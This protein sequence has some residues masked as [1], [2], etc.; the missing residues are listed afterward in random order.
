VTRILC[1]DDIPDNLKLL[2]DDL[3][4]E[5]FEVQLASSGEQALLA[6]EESPPDAILLD[7]MMPGINGLEVLTQIRKERNLTELPI[8]MTTA[9]GDTEHIVEALEAGAN[10]Y[11]VKPLEIEVVLARL[12]THLRLQQLAREQQEVLSMASHDLKNPLSCVR[13][14]AQIL[15]SICQVDSPLTQEAFD[16]F[17]RIHKSTHTMLTIIEDFLELGILEAG[18]VQ[19]K[20]QPVDLEEIATAVMNPLLPSAQ[21]K[22]IDLETH[23]QEKVRVQADPDRLQQVLGNLIGNA[24]KFSPK[25]KSV[26]IV[27]SKNQTNGILEVLD[28]GPGFSAE[29]LERI[30]GKF[31]KL[32]ARPTAGEKSSGLGLFICQKLTK[33][34]GGKLEVTNRSEQGAC[35]QVHHVLA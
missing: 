19:V 31:Q 25:G 24:I 2:Q 28:Q 21:A 27:I 8:L 16:L 4:D 34:Q 14:F 23:S 5:G 10:D 13:G 6:V 17:E 9:L 35:F 29:D 32:S 30:F 20:L 1:V 7:I 3:E 22:G 18:E 12:R 26:R 11:V 33:A 15:Q